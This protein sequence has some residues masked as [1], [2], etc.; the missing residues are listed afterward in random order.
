MPF[1]S[2]SAGPVG[3]A[4]AQHRCPDGSIDYTYY[5]RI[6]AYE[7]AAAFARLAKAAAS[8]V[9]RTVLLWRERARTR[10][11]LASMDDRLRRDIGLSRFRLIQEANKP[12]WRA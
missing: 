11:D 1:D 6:A 7:R 2:L 10:R 12:F 3:L 8:A 4:P 9:A 5:R